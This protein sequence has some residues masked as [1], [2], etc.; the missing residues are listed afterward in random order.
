VSTYLL[1][2]STVDGQTR[3]ISERIGERL[4]AH[5]HTVRLHSL[6]DGPPPA[7]DAFDAA[8]LGAGVRYGKHLPDAAAFVAAHRAALTQ[9]PSAFFSVNVVARKPGRDT[10]QTNQYARQFLTQTQW[11]PTHVAVFAGRIEYP[12]YGFL[13]RNVIRLIM[14]MTKGPTDPR[15]TFEFTEWAKV[16]AFAQRL[17]AV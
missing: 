17:A 6:A 2:Y 10:E 9:K 11:R 13:D 4:T 8:V 7:I 16:D 14:W 1:A 12:R 3:R 5:G 15:G